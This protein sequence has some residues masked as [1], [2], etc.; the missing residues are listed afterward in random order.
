MALIKVY[1]SLKYLTDDTR[2]AAEKLLSALENAG[3][4]P[5]VIDTY[6]SPARQQEIFEKAKYDIRHN[7]VPSTLTG[8]SWHE[9]GRALDIRISPLTSANGTALDNVR[10]FHSIANSLGFKTNSDPDMI[11]ARKRNGHNYGDL[12]DWQHVSFRGG[13]TSW[14]QAKRE[15][16]AMHLS[17]EQNPNLFAL[18]GIAT[19]IGGFYK[20]AYDAL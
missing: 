12:W 11:A 18:I 19:T 17:P 3:L 6:R 15:Y 7:K 5:V 20:W 14:E 13:R 16:D 1:N 2:V 8:N 4:N 9:V 10:L